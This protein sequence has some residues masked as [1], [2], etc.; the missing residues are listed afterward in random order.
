LVTITR[1]SSIPR[2]SAISAR[3]PGVAAGVGFEPL[4]QRRRGFPVGVAR[5]HPHDV[6]VGRRGVLDDALEQGF[7]VGVVGV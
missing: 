3:S 7:V 4:A 6:A 1:D 2:R 5:D